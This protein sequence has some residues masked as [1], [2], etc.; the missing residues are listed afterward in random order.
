MS[1]LVIGCGK[2][3]GALV[4]RWA[5]NPDISI[6]VVAPSLQVAPRGTAMVNHSSELKG[7]LFDKVVIAVKPQVIGDVVPNYLPYIADGAC[8]MSIAAGVSIESLMKVVGNRPVI[9]MMPNLPAEIG[10]GVT[11]YFANENASASDTAFAKL[12]TESVGMSLQVSQE[13][14]LD[15]VT[16][17]AG[18]GTGYAFEIIRCW[19]EAAESI[20]LSASVSRELVLATV[21]GAVDLAQAKPDTLEAL[22]DSV[23]SLNGTTAAGLAKLREN[24]AMENLMKAT[25][26]AALA[27]AVELR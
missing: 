10:K 22:R 25:V 11:G 21:G 5:C 20:G 16:A 8:V 18:S 17:I 24:Q 19:M 6:T 2:M 27:R 3:G 26:D 9:R 7:M 13:E 4:A 12:L 15:K 1:L 23:T 14:D